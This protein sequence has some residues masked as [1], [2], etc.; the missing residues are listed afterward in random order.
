MPQERPIEKA[1]PS[2]EVARNAS[3]V[4]SVPELLELIL[5][6]VARWPFFKPRNFRS[7][8]DTDSLI[9]LYH[10][11]LVCK[12]W[13]G[14]VDT[15]PSIS[16]KLWKC[17][18]TRLIPPV[19]YQ[20]SPFNC[21]VRTF[22]R[23]GEF[24]PTINYPFISWLAW[25]VPRC[26]GDGIVHNIRNLHDQYLQDKFPPS[27]FSNPPTTEVLIELGKLETAIIPELC[28]SEHI[29]AIWIKRMD[30]WNNPS[31]SF[32][33]KHENGVT[34]KNIIEAIATLMDPKFKDLFY[35]RDPVQSNSFREIKVGIFKRI[36]QEAGL[37]NEVNRW[38]LATRYGSFVADEPG[39][40]P[41]TYEI[42]NKF[43]L[44]AEQR[45]D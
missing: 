12:F 31:Q 9:D 1:N 41:Q 5:C 2:T 37:G 43:K 33:V 22:V 19:E 42:S 40:K 25:R 4:L 3:S 10:C 14:I 39:D 44:Y 35:D 26:F 8:K 11:S 20:K 23:E 24:Y 18:E 45:R 29:S 36:E 13:K 30:G 34:V 28:K 6:H 27:Y 38:S 15:S 17:D 32:I 7:V 21:Q 16:R